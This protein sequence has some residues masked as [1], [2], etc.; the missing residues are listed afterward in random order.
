MKRPMCARPGERTTSKTPQK[1]VSLSPRWARCGVVK[2]TPFERS[3]GRCDR[4]TG[5]R[6]LTGAL[7]D[8]NGRD[9]HDLEGDKDTTGCHIDDHKHLSAEKKKA[10]Q[11]VQLSERNTKAV[12]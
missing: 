2:E 9:E 1:G 7:C 12:Q 10:V 6:R 8:R 3:P 4:A 5:L 11:I